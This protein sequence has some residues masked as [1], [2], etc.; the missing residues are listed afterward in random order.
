M[1]KVVEMMKSMKRREYKGPMRAGKREE[2]AKNIRE[3]K[4]KELG[5]EKAEL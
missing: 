4:K 5:K 3:T 1:N 2:N